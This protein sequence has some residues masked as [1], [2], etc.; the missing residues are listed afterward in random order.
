MVQAPSNSTPRFRG[1][2][3]LYT[4]HFSEHAERMLMVF[5]SPSQHQSHFISAS[6]PCRSLLG[7]SGT[8][9]R[10]HKFVS[11]KTQVI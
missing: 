7:G 3:T 11:A 1:E 9:S 2:Q 6:F 8:Q 10:D 4:V 5:T